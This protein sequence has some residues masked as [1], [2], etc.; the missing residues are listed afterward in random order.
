MMFKRTCNWFEQ[1]HCWKIEQWFHFHKMDK[2]IEILA[3]HMVLKCT[4]IDALSFDPHLTSILLLLIGHWYDKK[5][6]WLPFFFEIHILKNDQITTVGLLLKSKQNKIVSWYYCMKT[7]LGL[8]L[9][10]NSDGIFQRKCS[11][12]TNNSYICSYWG[13]L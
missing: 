1:W 4:V 8:S 12:Q 5:Q 3:Y 6:A 11:S 9:F 2:M 10:S 13:K 7:R